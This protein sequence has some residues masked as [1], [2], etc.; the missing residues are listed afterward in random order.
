MRASNL[1]N[2]RITKLPKTGYIKSDG[3]LF[4]IT[5]ENLAVVLMFLPVSLTH[6]LQ[7]FPY[8]CKPLLSVCKSWAFF[9]NKNVYS[10][11]SYS[12][13]QSPSWEANRFSA[14][15]EIPR[16]SKEPKG[17]LLHS[18]V[19]ATCPY[20]QPAQSN[21]YPHIPKIHLNIILPSTPGSPKWSLSLR[22][23]HQSPL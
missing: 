9:W 13:E 21:S 16:I 19:P 18:Q 3:P 23:P 8:F 4:R 2:Y 20:H 6:I 11:L 17:S 7:F 22:V 5:P 10:L 14:S 12:M 15:Q 1:T